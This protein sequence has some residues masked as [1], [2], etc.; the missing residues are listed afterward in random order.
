MANQRMAQNRRLARIVVAED[1]LLCAAPN[2]ARR[3]RHHGGVALISMALFYVTV[4]S[5]SCENFDKNEL[6]Y[7][8]VVG[9]CRELA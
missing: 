2:H 8:D 7:N 4:E 3:R 6:R 1:V 9:D 5:I